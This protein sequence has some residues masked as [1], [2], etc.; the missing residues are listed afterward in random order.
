VVIEAL[1]G[2]LPGSLSRA[3]AVTVG[4]AI[5]AHIGRW[6]GQAAAALRTCW[7]ARTAVVK[8]DD[9]R[10]PAGTLTPATP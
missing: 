9:V 1:V 10:P 2:S 5:R 4:W 3:R 7:P 6:H 8:P